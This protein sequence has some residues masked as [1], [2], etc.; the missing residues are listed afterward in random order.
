MDDS[1][2]AAITIGLPGIALMSLCDDIRIIDDVISAPLCANQNVTSFCNI[3]KELS[4]SSLP[5]YMR[6]SVS[7]YFHC[8][9][10]KKVSYSWCKENIFV[11][12]IDIS[13]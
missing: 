2:P 7:E 12:Y 13:M 4:Y 5:I 1:T 10:K 6:L 3:G 9:D 8:L 11:F